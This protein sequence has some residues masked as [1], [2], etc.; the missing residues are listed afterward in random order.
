MMDECTGCGITIEELLQQYP[1]CTEEDIEDN[2]VRT[3]EG[4]YYCHIDCFRDSR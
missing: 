3:V 2:I 4:N 1:D